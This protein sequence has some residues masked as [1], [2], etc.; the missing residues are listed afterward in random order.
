[1]DGLVTGLDM[2]AITNMARELGYPARNGL[3]YEMVAAA[4]AGLLLGYHGVSV[5]D[6]VME[7]AEEDAA[8]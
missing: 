1:M 8:H 2:T 7:R 6:T 5:E 3:L 4:E